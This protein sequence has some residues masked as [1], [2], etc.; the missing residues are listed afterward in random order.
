MSP[1]KV[2]KKM[3]EKKRKNEIVLQNMTVTFATFGVKKGTTRDGV[4]YSADEPTYQIALKGENIP[5]DEIH[6]LSFN[7]VGKKLT[8]KWMKDSDGRIVMQ[9]KYDVPMRRAGKETSFSEWLDDQRDK[10]YSCVGSTVRVK[11][12]CG[13]GAVYPIAI[14]VLK[15]GEPRDPFEGMDE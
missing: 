4:E 10:G 15:D 14:I 8:P 5:Y 11:I 6:E 12:R 1:E 7:D 13:E 3:E 2:R 9:S